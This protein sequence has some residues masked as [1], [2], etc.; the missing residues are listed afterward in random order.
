MKNYK[1]D[2]TTTNRRNE[3]QYMKTFVETR[4]NISLKQ[5]VTYGT[6]QGTKKLPTGKTWIWT[7]LSKASVIAFPLVRWARF[8]ANL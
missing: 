7:N 6:F 3:C 4:T 8:S 1:A 5:D 2:V